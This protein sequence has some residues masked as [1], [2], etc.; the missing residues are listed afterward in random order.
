MA[1]TVRESEEDSE[2]G[3]V[4]VTFV[5]VV[6]NVVASLSRLP[7][8]RLPCV[9]CRLAFALVVVSPSGEDKVQHECFC[10]CFSCC[11]CY[12]SC[13]CSQ[14]AIS[15]MSL[16][17]RAYVAVV[18]VACASVSA[19]ACQLVLHTLYVPQIFA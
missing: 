17:Q 7:V 14:I 12:A 13:C 4:G 3:R 5:N 10:V 6:A 8:S 9:V 2:R 18:H 19:C 11:C 15:V 16:C 1:A